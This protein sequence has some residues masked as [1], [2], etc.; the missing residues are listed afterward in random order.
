M[1]PQTGKLRVRA[2]FLLHFGSLWGPFWHPRGGRK[3]KEFVVVSSV[4]CRGSFW[5]SWVAMGP[6]RPP[7][8]VPKPMGR[9]LGGC[10]W[11]LGNLAKTEPG[12][13]N[14]LVF[15]VRT[16]SAANAI[17]WAPLKDPNIRS[18]RTNRIWPLT[19]NEDP[20]GPDTPAGTECRGGF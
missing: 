5:D 10:T 1:R 15:S 19:G 7:G 12:A 3:T 13:S 2:S 4:A 14:H 18:F 8:G 6:P 20:F 17:S 9:R 16:K 11:P